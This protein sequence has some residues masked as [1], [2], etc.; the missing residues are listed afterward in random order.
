[1]RFLLSAGVLAGAVFKSLGEFLGGV[2]AQVVAFFSGEWKQ[3]IQIGQDTTSDFLGN[4]NAAGDLIATI[5][6]ETGTKVAAAAPANGKKIAAPMSAAAASTKKSVDKIAREADR[7]AKAIQDSLD[8]M[9]R[10]LA[11]FGFSEEKVKLFDLEMSGASE[12]QIEK[13]RGLLMSL[14]QLRDNN[15]AQQITSDAAKELEEQLKAMDAATPTAKIEEQRKAMLLLAEAYE[16]GR[17]GLVGS[18]E[19]MARYSEVASSFLGLDQAATETDSVASN[20]SQSLTDGILNGFRDGADAIDIFVSEMKAQFGKT[21]LQPIIE[22][23]VKFGSKLIGSALDS[24][25]GSLF[26]GLFSFAGGG[27]TPTGPRIGGID[28]KGGFLAVM[29]PNE[30]VTDYTRPAPA[31]GGG[32]AA[33]PNIYINASVGDIASKSDVEA[34][35]ASV[36]RQISGK[37]ARSSGYGGAF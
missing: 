7:A 2:A 16:A 15:T 5:W 24:I 23:I 6:D 32:G 11:V 3:A 8:A 31:R 30:G 25:A 4:L 33:A 1:V 21:I 12:E 20:L 10:D 36:A 14:K 37:F 27:D 22:P 28:G 18:T 13:A 34:G 17:Y 29:H 26:G 35:M 19:A 9:S